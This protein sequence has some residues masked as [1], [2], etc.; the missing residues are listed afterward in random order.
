[1]VSIDSILLTVEPKVK[2]MWVCFF[3]YGSEYKYSKP[4][5]CK[6]IKGTKVRRRRDK[7]KDISVSITKSLKTRRSKYII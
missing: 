2:Q 5:H 4:R 3:Y 6:K 7:N 1:M